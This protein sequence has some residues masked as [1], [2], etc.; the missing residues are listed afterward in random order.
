MDK[1]NNIDT[2]TRVQL[3]SKA[4]FICCGFNH[5]LII[6][7]DGSIYSCGHGGHG[8]LG[9]SN[10]KS[11]DIPKQILALKNK[12]IVKCEG[13][14][15]HSICMDENG[16][17]WTFGSGKYGQLGHSNEESTSAPKMVEYFTKNAITA[18]D[19]VA[20]AYHTGVI[21]TEDEL[22][23]FGGNDSYQL[24]LGDKKKILT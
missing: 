13:G 14:Q 17:V 1:G 20:G 8:R 19:C 22:Y 15:C 23:V 12:K 11:V 2:P 4:I 16:I 5:T 21:T 18:R 24:G 3:P 10:E 6:L 9:H 7:E